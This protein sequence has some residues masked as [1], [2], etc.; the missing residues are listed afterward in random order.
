MIK[1]KSD[2]LMH[3]TYDFS[4]TY[5]PLLQLCVAAGRAKL[6]FF[7]KVCMYFADFALCESVPA[8]RTI[9]RYNHAYVLV[10]LVYIN[11]SIIKIILFKNILHLGVT[12]SWILAGKFGKFRLFGFKN[13][14]KLQ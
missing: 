1:I 2:D 6:S 3:K 11:T 7:Y 4:Y 9:I 12:R 5:T 14:R 13:Y 10:V 8:L